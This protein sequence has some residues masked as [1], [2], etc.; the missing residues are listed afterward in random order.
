MSSVKG[1]IM[2]L[3]LT[4]FLI[5]TSI[6]SIFAADN[7]KMQCTP[8]ADSKYDACQLF[9]AWHNADGV[10]VPVTASTKYNTPLGSRMAANRLKTSYTRTQIHQHHPNISAALDGSLMSLLQDFFNSV[11]TV[12]EDDYKKR[13]AQGKDEYFISYFNRIQLIVQHELYQYLM[14]I[15]TTFNMTHVSNLDEYLANEARQAL[16]KK[17]LIINHLI[18]IIE[19]QANKAIT[20]R[21]PNMPQH[22]ATRMGPMMMQQDYGADLNLMMEGEEL[23]LFEDLDTQ[24]YYK[25]RR[26]LYLTIFGKYLKFFKS[27]TDT[28]YKDDEQYGVLFARYAAKIANILNDQQPAINKN[29]STKQKIEA[30]RAIKTVNP[31]LFFYNQEVMRGLRIIPVIARDLPKNA[32]L[33]KWPAKLVEDATKSAAITDRNGNIISS[34]PS[35]LF[36]TAQGTITTNQASAKQLFV[37]IPTAENMYTQEVKAQ[38]D[39]LN[40][41]EGVMLM[42][43][44]CLGDYTALFS[45][46]LKKE[47]I[48]DPCLSCIILNAALKV[49]LFTGSEREAVCSDCA[50]YLD[51][52]RSLIQE[53]KQDEP[54]PAP[55]LDF[56]V[57]T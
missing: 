14:A 56:G 49:N 15:Y 25:D 31:P 29:G 32:Q 12:V 42:L 27:Y 28:L 34:L 41:V 21:F 39:W 11:Q 2:Y 7:Q 38:P 53:T 46:Q 48:L 13:F 19:T 44:A 45:P 20:S 1:I 52:L 17:T 37:N 55:T 3:L 30:L 43:R 26:E 35:A 47:Q 33:I 5:T 4:R 18:N 36:L 24:K 50:S 57:G 54:P 22:L 23:K 10:K 8:R 51:Q 9:S 16:N 40:N 6:A